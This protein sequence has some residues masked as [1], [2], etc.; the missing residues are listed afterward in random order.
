MVLLEQIGKRRVLPAGLKDMHGELF[1]GVLIRSG[2]GG[3]LL[4]IDQHA[5]LREDG[6][7]ETNF[8][9]DEAADH[10]AAQKQDPKLKISHAGMA[11]SLYLHTDTHGIQD[12]S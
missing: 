9:E 10:E 3:G 5:L 11:G 12:R 1:P 2:H 6:S 8:L 4:L 7:T